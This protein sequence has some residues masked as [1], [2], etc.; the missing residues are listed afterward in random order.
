MY[1]LLLL[2]TG[3]VFVG[4]TLGDFTPTSQCGQNGKICYDASKDRIRKKIDEVDYVGGCRANLNL[5]NCLNSVQDSATCSDIQNYKI[6]ISNYTTGICRPDNPG[7]VTDCGNQLG[8]CVTQLY[9]IKNDFQ[10]SQA[11]KACP[12]IKFFNNCTSSILQEQICPKPITDK[13]NALLTG[14]S[15]E[16]MTVGCDGPCAQLIGNCT[17]KLVYDIVG[18][19]VFKLN[20]TDFCIQGYGA[21]KCVEAIP[22]TS[23]PCIA[24]PGTTSTV[25]DI[26]HSYTAYLQDYCDDKGQPSKCMADM[27]ECR[28]EILA[29][30]PDANITTQCRIAA[31]FL[32]CTS[33]LP[34]ETQLKTTIDSMRQ[35]FITGEGQ[36][37]CPTVGSCTE[38]IETCNGINAQLKTVNNNTQKAQFCKMVDSAVSCFDFVRKDPICINEKMIVSDFETM[39]AVTIAPACGAPIGSCTDRIKVCDMNE[40]IVTAVDNSTQRDEFCKRAATGASCF[41]GIRQDPA[42]KTD[43][44]ELSTWE[45]KLKNLVN[46][47]CNKAGGSAT[48]LPYVLMA[49][50]CIFIS[51]LLRL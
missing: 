24:R 21:R 50:L 10:N 38:R 1:T 37:H 47:Y 29:V 18:M 42:C 41:D 14:M 6:Q 43:K 11:K 34:C 45:T 7:L 13:L 26:M 16:D 5:L 46:P 23:G 40:K 36:Q 51:K 32:E 12:A 39:L 19:P 48:F 3:L 4:L 28:D 8:S 25:D 15:N 27:D 44:P 31:N 33:K 35:M 20:W 30:T 22:T 49:P 2:T 9:T 17:T